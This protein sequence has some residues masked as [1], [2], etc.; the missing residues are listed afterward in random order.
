MVNH[1]KSSITGPF[2]SSQTLKSSENSTWKSW[3]QDQKHWG[4]TGGS[5]AFTGLAFGAGASAEALTYREVKMIVMQRLIKVVRMLQ[6]S[7]R[8]GE[9]GAWN[10]RWRWS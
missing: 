10:D 5:W 4:D 2:S 8:A 3:F 6:R 1:P 7:P 9:K